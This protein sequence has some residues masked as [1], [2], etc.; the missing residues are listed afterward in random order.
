MIPRKLQLKNF[1]SYGSEIQTIDF[2]HYPLICLSG[3]NGH[4]K[5][6]LLDAIT[7]AIWG[8]ARKVSDVSKADEG[9][10]RLGQTQMLVILDFEFNNQTYRVRREF[11]KTYGKPYAVL[12]FGILDTATDT[13]NPLTE[14]TIRATQAKIESMLNLDV[15]SFINSAFLR[16]GQSNEFSKK[17][18]K[19]RKEVLAS[20]LGINRYE[21]VRKLALEKTKTAHAHKTALT[22][23]QATLERELQTKIVITQQLTDAHTTLTTI[24]EQEQLLA[25]SSTQLELAQK[26]LQDDQQ[27]QALLTQQLK[28]HDHEQLQLHSVLR[29]LRA[30]WRSFHATLLR[31][32]QHTELHERK[33]TLMG[34][35]THHQQGLQKTLELKEQILRTKES[36]QQI[37]KQISDTQSATMHIQHVTSERLRLEAAALEHQRT[38][39]IAAQEKL[40][41][42]EKQIRTTI[43]TLEKQTEQTQTHKAALAVIEQQF[44]KRKDYY[45]K[46]ITQGNWLKNELNGLEHKQTVVH[47]T[48]NP[49]CPLCEQNLSASRKKF[50]KTTFTKQEQTIKHQLTRLSSV[51]KNLKALLIEQHEQIATLKQQ[52]EN[53]TRA[54][55]QLEQARIT[56]ATLAAQKQAATDRLVQLDLDYMTKLAERA[57]AAEMLEKNPLKT[58][59][60]CLT[61]PVIRLQAPCSKSSMMSWRVL[62]TT[63][64]NIKRPL[65]NLT[66]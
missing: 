20:I 35:I 52:A 41:T 12:E 19:E 60:S 59:K 10:L 61:M 17:S 14:K 45:Q 34:T 40:T 5:S 9:L 64:M 28:Q 26:K 11:A 37:E 27:Q 18:A 23:V 6:A 48:D 29:G 30:Q 58:I 22:A 50:L 8:Q 33:L 51:I 3:K 13:L 38:E 43:G 49:S 25:S 54:M 7:W 44:E 66:P 32:S 63:P 56:C 39:L 4:G 31:Y 65:R 47:D 42:E 15:D 1:L 36:I 46:F 62:H 2:S 16:Q 53:T 55:V 57:Q 24:A 21:T